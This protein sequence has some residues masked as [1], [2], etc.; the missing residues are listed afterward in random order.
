MSTPV[1][2]FGFKRKFSPNVGVDEANTSSS[3]YQPTLANDAVNESYVVG[4]SEAYQVPGE[5]FENGAITT[6]KLANTCVTSAKFADSAIG[7]SLIDTGAVTTA[8][9]VDGA[10]NTSTLGNA[11]VTENKIA[12]GGV[13]DSA[14]AN[15][16]ITSAKIASIAVSSTAVADG[17]ITTD[18]ILDDAVLKTKFATGC[19]TAGTIQDSAV[20]FT[21][22]QD[23]A[24]TI[25]KLQTP[26]TLTAVSSTTGTFAGTMEF[27]EGASSTAMKMKIDTPTVSGTGTSE[28]IFYNDEDPLTT[29]HLL[30]NN[31]SS[32]SGDGNYLEYATVDGVAFRAGMAG[33]GVNFTFYQSASDSYDF[34]QC[35]STTPS[36]VFKI[37]SDGSWL[38]ANGNYGSISDIRIKKD[39]RPATSQWSDIKRI[40]LVSYRLADDW[41]AKQREIIRTKADFSAG[42]KK[43]RLVAKLKELESET[44]TPESEPQPVQIGVLAQDLQ[45]SGMQGLLDENQYGIKTVKYSVMMMK[46][47]VA[48]QEAMRTVEELEE[49]KRTKET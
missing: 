17:A 12:D 36:T 11:S 27:K 38:N 5:K 3:N 41:H 34:F 28:F 21:K 29:K 42:K 44:K 1:S 35:I 8:K 13:T 23:G 9:I 6:D 26:I 49:W 31:S 14:I 20:T 4:I 19:I 24:V 40:K 47:L 33:Q 39:I 25:A 7:A 45:T 2:Y 43:E 30:M 15:G 18:K 32:T 37:E 10:I 46:A 48:I 16:A 22:I